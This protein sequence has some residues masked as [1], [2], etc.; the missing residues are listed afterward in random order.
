VL[1]GKAESA[2]RLLVDKAQTAL[3]VAS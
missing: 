2:F 1:A 3:G